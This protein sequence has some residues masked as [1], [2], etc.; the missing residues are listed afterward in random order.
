M[1]SPQIG[2]NAK[3]FILTELNTNKT[4]KL[5]IVLNANAKHV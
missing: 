3:R 1:T 4:G 5:I 2:N